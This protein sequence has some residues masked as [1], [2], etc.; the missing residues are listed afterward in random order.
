MD[1]DDGFDYTKRFN[2]ARRRLDFFFR[3][4]LPGDE[5]YNPTPRLP[6]RAQVIPKTLIDGRKKFI[7]ED[8]GTIPVNYIE[9]IKAG[10]KYDR[11]IPVRGI[12]FDGFEEIHITKK[13]IKTELSCVYEGVFIDR[14]TGSSVKVAVK[15]QFLDSVITLGAI[16]D[17]RPSSRVKLEDS[18]KNMLVQRLL[19]FPGHENI[20]EDYM[21]FCADVE[22]NKVYKV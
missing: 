9:A 19:N 22:R 8:F 20:M 6:V 2:D 12:E 21:F 3:T 15:E 4:L 17:T 1:D 18:L 11:L 10:G 5:L 14:Y 7:G 16:E 13:I